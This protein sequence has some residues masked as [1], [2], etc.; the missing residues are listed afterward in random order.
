MKVLI[1]GGAG[2]IGSNYVEYLFK[3]VNQLSNVT[4]YDNFTYAANP[5]NYFE[6]ASDPR[7]TV[8]RGDIC[9]ANKLENAMGDHD[10]V[11][12]FA[13]MAIISIIGQSN[14][15]ELTSNSLEPKANLF[16]NVGL[17]P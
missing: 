4:I 13:A 12:H 5:K 8:I 1:T 17:E 15:S 7:L 3:H 10:Y 9:D 14:A 11:V 6:F 16:F 2:F